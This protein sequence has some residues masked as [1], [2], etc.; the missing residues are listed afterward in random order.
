MWPFCGRNLGDLVESSTDFIEDCLEALG[1]T[2]FSEALDIA[3]AGGANNLLKST[4]ELRLK[5]ESSHLATGTDG[6]DGGRR[7]EK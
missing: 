5:R 4:I 6:L 7:G 1:E 3:E 2:V